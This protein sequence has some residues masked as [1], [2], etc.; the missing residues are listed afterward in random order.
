MSCPA[1]QGQG[2]LYGHGQVPRTHIQVCRSKSAWMHSTTVSPRPP[3]RRLFLRLLSAMVIDAA[4]PST[5]DGVRSPPEGAYWHCLLPGR[6][7]L[8]RREGEAYE[9][10]QL[11][12]DLASPGVRKLLNQRDGVAPYSN[13]RERMVCD[14]QITCF[15][16][17]PLVATVG[18]AQDGFAASSCS[19]NV[20]LEAAPRSDT[21]PPSFC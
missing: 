2:L 19:R 15:K 1:R 9:K 16:D 7:P 6:H 4:P 10:A 13:S 12:S 18:P 11:G 14:L 3:P 21:S 8:V 20:E 17:L 5:V